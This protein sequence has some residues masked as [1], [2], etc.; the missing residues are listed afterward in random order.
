MK[1][2]NT[3]AGKLILYFTVSLLF[4][5]IVIGFAFSFLFAHQTT[6]LHKQELEKKAV[7]IANTLGEFMNGSSS[8]GMGKQGQIGYGAYMR[9]LD[10]I[11]MTDVWVMDVNN[12]LVTYGQGSYCMS[13]NDLPA[14][15]DE[16]IQPALAGNIAFGEGFSELLGTRSITVG[17]PIQTSNGTVAGV[18][19]LHTPIEGIDDAIADG[20]GLLGISVILAL[21][22]ASIAAILLAVHFTKPLR[23]MKDTAILLAEGDYTARTQITQRDEIGEL[24]A[25]LDVLADR[26]A[27]AAEESAHL[28]QM[29]QDFVANISH[30]L[31]T[32][33]TVIR[34]SLEALCDGVVTDPSQVESYHH[35]MLTDSIFLQRLVDDLLDLSRLQN[36]DFAIEMTDINLVDILQDVT[37]SMKHI[38]QKKQVHISLEN[39]VPELTIT[40]DYGRIRQMLTIVVNNAIKFSYENE[41]VLLKLSS[42]NGKRVLSVIDHGTEISPHELPYIFDRFYKSRN[43]QNKD[44]TGLGLAIAKQIAQRHGIEISAQSY[45]SKTIFNFMF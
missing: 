36:T 31:R 38:A 27:R 42:E 19:L 15:A 3:I 26:L 41:T 33:V 29:R 6:A 40:G 10:K 13:Y 25:T 43:E 12:N 23:Y 5:S 22:F 28:S 30:E 20:L 9:F 14:D 18:V 35:Q 8:R 34:G 24:A 11:A 7:S 17:A 37:R 44:G 1:L 21:A 4:F 2:N 39:E 45:S 16:V 32:P